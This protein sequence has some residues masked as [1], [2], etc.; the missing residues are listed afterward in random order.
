MTRSEPLIPTPDDEARQRIHQAID[1]TLVVEAAAGTGKTTELVRRIVR[2]LAEGRADV[3]EIVAVTF[4]EKAAGKLKLRLRQ[5]LEESRRDA[6]APEIQG[7][8]DDAVQHLEEAHVSTIHG[9]CADLLRERPV[10]ASI[11]PL[12]RVLTEGQAER[13]FNEAFASWFQDVLARPP[14]GVRRSLRRASRGVR[15]GD[16]DEDGP[17]ERLR[18]AG[19][20]LTEWRDFDQPW[21][22]EPFDR[23]GA[24]ERLVDLVLATGRAL[25][26][27]V[28]ILA[29]VGFIIGAFSVTGLAGTLAND[30]VYIAGSNPLILLLM[31]AITSF[32]FGMGMTVTACYIFLAIVL[33]PPLVKAGLDPLAVHLFIMYWGMI[34][35][36]TPPVALATF[37]AAPLAR[38][39]P[40][41]CAVMLTKSIRAGSSKVRYVVRDFIVTPGARAVPRAAR[42]RPP[43][44]APRRDRRRCALRGRR[45]TRSRTARPG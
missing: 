28:A 42:A 5:Q 43:S 33:A 14:E 29:G 25:A 34:S 39:S 9:F 17:T 13:L 37:A 2:V 22:R 12:F 3:R 38:T 7:R 40:A 32:I 11:D 19:F 15:P 31:G 8:L 1:E 23:A 36:I 26:E 10:E 45:G 35:F 18:R 4:T 16:V 41:T 21:T 27:L 24:I 20:A 44:G 6:H 30:L